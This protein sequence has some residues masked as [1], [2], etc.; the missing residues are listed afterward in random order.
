MAGAEA[1][2]HQAAVAEAGWFFMP[3]AGAAD[4]AGR[5]ARRVLDWLRAAGGGHVVAHSYGAN[6]AVLAAQ[7]EPSLVRSLA[8]LEPTCF[9]L[10]RGR[11]AVEEHIAAMAPVFAVADD[12][13]VSARDFSRRFAAGMGVEPPDL[14][15]DELEVRVSRLRALLPP[16]GI[17]LQ[18]HRGLS[19]R[20]LVITGGWS[21]LYEET[22][23][24][25]DASG[26]RHLILAGAGHRIQDDPQA[27]QLLRE[28]WSE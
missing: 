14:R 28:H 11:P 27:T 7:L 12:S 26:A 5:D 18:P 21:P 16:W 25:L 19:A 10:A 24:S 20:T 8:L 22:A 3:R 1:W 6:A 2:P 4:N 23:K 9:D 15:D 13:S 17:G